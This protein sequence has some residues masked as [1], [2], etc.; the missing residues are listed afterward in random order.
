MPPRHPPI[1]VGGVGTRAPGRRPCPPPLATPRPRTPQVHYTVLDAPALAP[2][3]E[4]V[5]ADA[6]K[7][8]ADDD[9]RGA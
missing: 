4:V 9:A 3:L 6:A 1:F 2:L 8:R 5:N 7:E